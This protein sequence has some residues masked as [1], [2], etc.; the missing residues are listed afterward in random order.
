MSWAEIKKA[1][2][3][4]TETLWFRLEDASDSDSKVYMLVDE[5]TLTYTK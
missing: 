4:D 5:M 2:N 1:V 3:S